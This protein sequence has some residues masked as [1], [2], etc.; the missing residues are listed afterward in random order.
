MKIEKIKQVFQKLDLSFNNKVPFIHQ[1]ESSEC[2]LACLSMICGFYGK[3]IDMMTLR[4]KYRISSRGINLK[5]ITIIAKRL[6]LTS[7]ALSV[8]LQ[9]I[10]SLRLPVIIHW[11]FNHFVVLVKVTSTKVVIYD[12]AS[13]PRKMNI[14]ELSQHFT[15]VVLE[16]WPS[17]EFKEE[18]I[19]K[20]LGLRMLIN[21][22]H[23]IKKVLLNVFLFSFIIELIGILIPIGSQLVIDHVIPVND[24]QLLMLICIGIIFFILFRTFVAILRSW[25]LLVLNTLIEIQWKI[26]LFSHL[27]QLSLD[28]FE[29]RKLGDIQSRFLSVDTLRNI[30]TTNI[31]GIIIDSI[32]TLGIL[33]VMTIY[34]V[35]LTLFVVAFLL[36]YVSVRLFTYQYYKRLSEDEILRD[37]RVNSHF[38]ESLYGIVTIKM[39]GIRVKRENY[40]LN[41]VIDKVN[42][43]IKL[44]KMNIFFDSVNTLIISLEQVFFLWLGVIFIIDSKITM[45]MF[46]AFG[47]L[48]T[49]LSNRVTSLTDYILELRM[50]SI[51]SERVSDIALN[52]VYHD[53]TDSF[54]YENKQSAS[55]EVKKLIYSYD[56]QSRPIFDGLDINIRSGESVAIVGSSG[57][58]KTTLLKILSGLI[59]QDSGEIL[60]DNINI[61]QLGLNN[62]QKIISCVMQEDKLFSGSLEENICGFSDNIDRNWMIECANNADI[63]HII[64]AMPMQYETL[65][66]ELGEGLSGGQKQRLFIARA[67]YR[68]P[69][70]LFMDEAT[71]HLDNQS[72][73]KINLAIKKLSITRIIVAHRESTILSADRV[74]HL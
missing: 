54:R 20:K 62:Y 22:V 15:G 73:E 61:K 10:K 2:G 16:T 29:R 67:L 14:S 5:D 7:R 3:N 71:S 12:P 27:M 58:G 6:G 69:S 53:E 64:M 68:K 60:I 49:Q 70:I 46:F 48:R 11:D 40:W 33:T 32:I 34:N 72:E 9:S 35:K 18:T 28:Y 44:K 66:G 31:V 25:A 39:Q 30:F 50:L 41:L 21:S 59:K 51:H 43:S 23:G 1:A 57:V 24:K 45:G 8:D 38:M 63:H 26:S 37:A 65:I 47:L 74:I 56:G 55:L 19:Q 36:V 17:S 13:G 4:Q 42:S 52:E